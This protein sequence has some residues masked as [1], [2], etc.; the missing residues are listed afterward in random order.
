MDNGEKQEKGDLY[1]EIVKKYAQERLLFIDG[2]QL[3]HE[4]SYISADLTHPSLEGIE[5][6]ADR[7]SRF[8]KERL[9]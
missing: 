4:S 3:L 7:W 1:R 8:M 2:L 5:R 6:I 9:V